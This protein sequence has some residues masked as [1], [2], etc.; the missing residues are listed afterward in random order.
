MKAI[1]FFCFLSV[2]VFIVAEASSLEALK[3]FE[4]ER[5]CVGEN[6]RCRDWYNDCCDG[7]YCSCRQPPYCICRNNNG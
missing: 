4:G 1:I 3:I 5:D 2:M 6:G 7:F